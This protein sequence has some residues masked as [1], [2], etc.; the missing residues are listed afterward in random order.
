MQPA[1]KR[2][3]ARLLHYTATML[4]GARLSRSQ[5][6][7][8]A[9]KSLEPHPSLRDGERLELLLERRHARRLIGGG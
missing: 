1:E 7:G 8:A 3:Q 6:V 4:L 2:D 5:I 9:A